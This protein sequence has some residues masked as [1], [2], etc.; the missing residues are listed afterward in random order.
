MSDETLASHMTTHLQ[1]LP[2]WEDCADKAGH[3]QCVQRFW[4]FKSSHSQL[5][6]LPF[7][8]EI[9]CFVLHKETQGRQALMEN[10]LYQISQSSGYIYQRQLR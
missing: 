2:C 7:Q 5:C 3:L 9:I 10:N 6:S 4:G 8:R 1:S